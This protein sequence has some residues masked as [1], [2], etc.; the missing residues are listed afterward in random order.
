MRLVGEHG[1][2]VI[3]HPAGETAADRPVVGEDQVGEVVARDDR[4]AEPGRT[5]HAIDGQRVVRD[6]RL[7][8]IGD[9]VKDAAEVEGEQQ[10]LVDVEEAAL[11]LQL[12]L[13]F[14]LL[15][16]EALEVAGVHHGLRRVRGED[17]QRRLV[18]RIELIAPDART[19]T[20][21]P[22]R[23]PRTSSAR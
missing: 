22:E 7:E 3:D 20:R 11:A 8:R 21:P 1:L 6:D 9:E 4:A 12:P 16:L 19:T 14:P 15:A 10:A 5:V 2:A 13:E 23:R 18:V 17:R